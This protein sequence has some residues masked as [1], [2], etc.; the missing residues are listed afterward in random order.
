[1]QSA[2]VTKMTEDLFLVQAKKF[3]KLISE[4]SV[5][6][7]N[8]GKQVAVENLLVSEEMLENGDI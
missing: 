2:S 4:D 3:S 8:V 6:K 5:C 1:M 7:W